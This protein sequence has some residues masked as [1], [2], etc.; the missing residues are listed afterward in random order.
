MLN[1]HSALGLTLNSESGRTKMS[2]I[3]THIDKYEEVRQ[4]LVLSESQCY[5]VPHA[6]EAIVN[7]KSTS[8]H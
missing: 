8:I 1:F 3:Y 2:H 7:S 6:R 5:M 4:H